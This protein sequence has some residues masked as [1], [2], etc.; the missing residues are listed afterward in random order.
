MCD[1]YEDGIIRMSC[2][3]EVPCSASIS[4]GWFVDNC[5]QLTNSTDVT[6]TT[7]TQSAATNCQIESTLTIENLDD[8]YAGKYT[9]NILGDEEF[10]PSHPLSLQTFLDLINLLP[11]FPCAEGFVH[12]AYEM[13]C[14]ELFINQDIPSSLSCT[15]THI[16]ETSSVTVTLSPTPSSTQPTST[17]PQE[18][19]T[20][21]PKSTAAWLYVVVAV[22]AVFFIIIMF[23]IAVILGMYKMRQQTQRDI[24]IPGMVIIS[25]LYCYTFSRPST[26]TYA[27]YTGTLL[28]FSL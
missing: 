22:T 12:T 1:P 28:P 4:M 7:Q 13:K 26:H 16:V 23:L 17:E 11:V 19:P 10:I 2:I 25:V 6:I 24:H 20:S 3:V 9:C 21:S 27:I 5:D 14:A 15:A 18:P 8:S